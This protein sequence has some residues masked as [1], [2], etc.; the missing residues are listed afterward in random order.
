[1]IVLYASLYSVASGLNVSSHIEETSVDGSFWD[2]ISIFSD[3]RLKEKLLI[4]LEVVLIGV[5]FLAAVMALAVLFLLVVS[6]CRQRCS[7]NRMSRQQ[8]QR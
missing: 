2:S 7:R 4:I 5:A 6:K 8:S 1:G 3:P